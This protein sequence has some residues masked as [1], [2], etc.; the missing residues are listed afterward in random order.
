MRSRARAPRARTG[1]CRPARCRTVVE[2]SAASRAR[3][4]CP[5]PPAGAARTIVRASPAWSST[6]QL[7]KYNRVD[8]CRLSGAV[9]THHFP[10]GEERRDERDDLGRTLLVHGVAAPLD[11][12]HVEPRARR[13]QCR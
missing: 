9:L 5:P 13:P 3:C 12:A 6:F 7:L 2:E 11:L 10:M 8:K 4:A 1:V